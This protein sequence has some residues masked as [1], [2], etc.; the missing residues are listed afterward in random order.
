MYP[1]DPSTAVHDKT[2]LF[3]TGYRI[4]I[5]FS[6]MP[7][8]FGEPGIKQKIIQ[9]I[10]VRGRARGGGVVVRRYCSLILKTYEK[11]FFFFINAL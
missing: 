10:R 4:A 11:E 3:L 8:R 7:P 5:Y 9:V 1:P 2:P 6:Q